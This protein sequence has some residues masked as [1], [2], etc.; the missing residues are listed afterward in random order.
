M[1][2]DFEEPGTYTIVFELMEET[3][4]IDQAYVYTENGLT[5]RFGGRNSIE[6]ATALAMCSYTFTVE[7]ETDR[8]ESYFALRKIE[9][10]DRNGFKVFY[11]KS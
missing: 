5:R 9:L 4:G 11:L 8:V 2:Y 3:D 6:G 10:K 1:T 7:T